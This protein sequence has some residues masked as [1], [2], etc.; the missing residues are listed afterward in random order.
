MTAVLIVGV[1][2]LDGKI[3]CIGGW[4]GQDGM[5]ACHVYDP[6]TKEWTKIAPLNERMY[7]AATLQEARL[8]FRLS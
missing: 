1:S 6:D 4:S 8:V 2:V 5:K 7:S 3:Y